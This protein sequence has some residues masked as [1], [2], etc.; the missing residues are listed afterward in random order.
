MVE[1]IVAKVIGKGLVKR[2]SEDDGDL[3]IK[4]NFILDDLVDIFREKMSEVIFQELEVKGGYEFEIVLKTKQLS[5]K[6]YKNQLENDEEWLDQI[7]RPEPRSIGVLLIDGLKEEPKLVGNLPFDFSEEDINTLVNI[8]KEAET[9]LK[10]NV[11]HDI[12]SIDQDEFD[13]QLYMDE[14]N[15]M[16][17][18]LSDE[19]RADHMRES[20]ANES[21]EPWT[22]AMCEVEQEEDNPYYLTQY[23]TACLSCFESFLGIKEEEEEEEN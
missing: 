5:K 16:N 4:Q 19:E 10:V 11:F 15:K 7:N 23:G 6:G 22:C 2:K 3:E 8:S 12:E 1:K 9:P 17:H 21:E 20:M 13:S 18:S 14:Y